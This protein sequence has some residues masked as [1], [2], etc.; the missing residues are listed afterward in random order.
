MSESCE[1]T[2]Y[3]DDRLRDYQKQAI[4]DMREA[5]RAGARN[6]LICAPT[7]SGKTEIASCLADLNRKKGKRSAFVVD[8]KSLIKQTSDAFD[9]HGIEHGVIQASH[10][11]F[12]PS[13]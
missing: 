11:R 9:V 4:R 10:P 6:V 3:W 12:R 1:F 7:G 5:A 2:P 8:R 13:L